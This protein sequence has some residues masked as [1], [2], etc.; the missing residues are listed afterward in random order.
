MAKTIQNLV[1]VDTL[2]AIVIIDNEIDIMSSVAPNTI[3]N[4]G[5]MPNLSL[6]QPDHVHGR[7][8]ATKEMPMEAI[9]CGAHGL[10]I[11]VVWH[12]LHQIAI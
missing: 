12:T 5:R 9:C 6:A 10:S 3:I 7:G 11:L 8:E 2:E 1:E 4:S